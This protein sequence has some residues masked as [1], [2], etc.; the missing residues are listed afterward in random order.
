MDFVAKIGRYEIE[1]ELGRGAMGVVYL[2]RD[3]QLHRRVAIKTFTNPE[4][5]SRGQRKEFRERFVREA[6]AAARLTHPGV[7]TVYDVGEEGGVPFFTMEY[8]PGST[9]EQLVRSGPIDAALACSIAD[10]VV[11]A[12][13]A[14]HEA[15]IVHRDV[16]PANIL[17][18]AGDEAVKVA[19]FGVARLAASDLTRSGASIGSPAYMSPEQ[20]R[21]HEVD[22]RS[23]LFSLAVI[24]YEM[25]CGKRPFEGEDVSQLA[26]SIV[27]L[28][29]V[30]ISK[31]VEGLSSELDRFFDRALAKNP[32]DRFPDG[33]AF[34]DALQKARVDRP[35][36]DPLRTRVDDSSAVAGPVADSTEPDLAALDTTG[37][38]PWSSPAPR[39]ARRWRRTASIVVLLAGMLGAWVVFGW[40]RGAYL[41]L[42]A[43]SSVEAGSF[44]LL[45]DGEEVY[46]RELAVQS[47]RKGLLGKVF[48]NVE[49]FE[50][51]I[52]V[53][54]GAHEVVGRV[55]PDDGSFVFQDT[56]VVT[57]EPRQ[58]H[59]L[60]MTAG[61]SF[62][63]PLALKID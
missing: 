12:L 14:A 5:L 3:P 17:V 16:K 9:L 21:G 31:R 2:A 28:T 7:V 19:D 4:G 29:P 11:Q 61:R 10:R 63:S 55:V 37:A 62:G 8:V 27:H 40:N 45:V 44:A 30:P 24:L 41:L 42:D 48:K 52:E 49:T 50:A 20:I 57:F 36:A 18:R 26:Y 46:S 58:T 32:Q 39:K 43:K 54:A 51:L 6:R 35:A 1:T 38:G 59:K 23:D 25:L 56:V 53:P 33:T 22:G 34:R 47:P 60:R 15:G 13:G